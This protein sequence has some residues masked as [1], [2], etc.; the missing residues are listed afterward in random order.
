M[1]DGTKNYSDRDLYCMQNSPSCQSTVTGR[2]LPYHLQYVRDGKV[3]IKP[4]VKDEPE[5]IIR[6]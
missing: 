4:E 6:H 3:N 2:R 5:R 1:K